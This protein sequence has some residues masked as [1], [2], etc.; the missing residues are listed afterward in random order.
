[1]AVSAQELLDEAERLK[2]L[3]PEPDYVSMAEAVLAER[4]RIA[5]DLLLNARNQI[6]HMHKI[7]GPTASGY[8]VIAQIDEF[9]APVREGV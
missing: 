5:D 7:L 1:M 9:L 8:G 3:Y 6:E 4:R 2:R